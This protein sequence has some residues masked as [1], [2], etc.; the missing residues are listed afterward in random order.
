MNEAWRGGREPGGGTLFDARF[1]DAFRRSNGW[2][3]VAVA[4]QDPFQD[5][6]PH[7]HRQTHYWLDIE[8]GQIVPIAAPMEKSLIGEALPAILSGYCV[9]PDGQ[10]Q[11][12]TLPTLCRADAEASQITNVLTALKAQGLISAEVVSALQHHCP[13]LERWRS[14]STDERYEAFLGEMLKQGRLQVAGAMSAQQ[15]EER[16]AASEAL[17]KAIVVEERQRELKDL[18]GALGI[19]SSSSSAPAP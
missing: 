12:H 16:H 4:R 15:F 8:D 1:L 11:L 6:V 19:A 13:S 18:A 10:G 17:V 7:E 9:W 5:A 2:A 3:F 14:Y